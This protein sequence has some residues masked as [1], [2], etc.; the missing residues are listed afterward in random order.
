MSD[1]TQKAKDAVQDVMDDVG[2]AA[3]DLV[4]QLIPAIVKPLG[5]AAPPSRSFPRVYRARGRPARPQ[6]CSPA[7]VDDAGRLGVTHGLS[8]AVTL[9][10]PGGAQGI[11]GDARPRRHQNGFLPAGPSGATRVNP[12]RG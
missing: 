1:N 9:D 7:P 12:G 6:A 2:D 8:T 10:G 4:H 5:H 3:H 11:V